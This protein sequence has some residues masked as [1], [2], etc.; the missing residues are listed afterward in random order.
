MTSAVCR[1]PTLQIHQGTGEWRC[2][3]EEP[4]LS[5][6][7]LLQAWTGHYKRYSHGS[8]NTMN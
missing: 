6:M 7:F 5:F 2:I 1:F 8:C 4:E 3:S